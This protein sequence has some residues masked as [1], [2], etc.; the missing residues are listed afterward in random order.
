MSKLFKNVAR[1]L[2]LGALAATAMAGAACAQ[3]S[4]TQATTSTGTIL[5]PIVLTKTADLAFGTIVRP[6][7][8]SGVLTVA[9]AS[10]SRTTTAGAII[11]TS[12]F[13]RAGYTIAGEGGQTYSI[14][15]PATMTMT[16]V[17][18]ADTLA[19]TLTS[20][21]TSGALTNALGA[22]GAGSFFVGGALPIANTTVSGAYTG[23]FNAV[24][25]Y[26]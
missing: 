13:S 8:G 23:T 21:A 26:N 2:L 15:V 5:Q 18:G 3:A 25:A 12:T 17:G 14:T 4:S 1:N 22:A 10:V 7:T 16:R 19:V 24:V 20:T 11:T 9:A 6:T